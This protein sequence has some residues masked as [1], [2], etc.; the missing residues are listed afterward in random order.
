MADTPKAEVARD[1]IVADMENREAA[2]EQIWQ[3]QFV[4]PFS[5]KYPTL[6]LYDTKSA[7]F[8]VRRA[9]RFLLTNSV[10]GP[11][12]LAH[13]GSLTEPPA[14]VFLERQPEDGYRRETWFPEPPR[15]LDPPMYQIV[16]Y[17]AA[18]SFTNQPGRSFVMPLNNP[19][20]EVL[21]IEPLAFLHDD[22]EWVYV[23]AGR[24]VTEPCPT[25]NQSRYRVEQRTSVPAIGAG[26][27]S[28]EAWRSALK[29]LT[30][31]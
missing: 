9:V 22:G 24:E 1:P 15:Q 13:D 21:A 3:Q 25:C 12:S 20:E 7:E 10:D 27:S 28:E 8:F 30:A 2:F 26:P 17:L 18:S 4:E 6:P 23:Y 16:E 11:F 29:T 31:R 14:R 5:K 19:K